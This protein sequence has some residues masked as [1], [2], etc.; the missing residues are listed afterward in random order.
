MVGRVEEV[1]VLGSEKS[2]Q[3]QIKSVTN[4]EIL[5]DFNQRSLIKTEGL[6]NSMGL[7]VLLHYDAIFWL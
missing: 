4:R 5:R 3:R 2:W 6:I 7:N 1:H